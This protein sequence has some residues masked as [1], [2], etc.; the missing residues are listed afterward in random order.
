ME[1]RFRLGQQ[2]WFILAWIAYWVALF[3]STHI[4]RVPWPS[5][6]PEP[7]DK[8]LHVVFYFGLALMGWMVSSGRPVAHRWTNVEWFSV[9]AIYG[10]FDE[11]TQP[12]VN[13]HCSILDWFADMAGSA[14]AIGLMAMVW[15]FGRKG[16]ANA[17][18]D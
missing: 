4:P 14:L 7:N 10:A 11:V 13:R 6:L 17:A 12:M 1:S 18:P 3:V 8:T 2:P 9:L 5:G 15:R 16:A